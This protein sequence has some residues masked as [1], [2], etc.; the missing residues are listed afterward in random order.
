M[1]NS[2]TKFFTLVYQNFYFNESINYFNSKKRNRQLDA[3]LISWDDKLKN[4]FT[5]IPPPPA[6]Q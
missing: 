6:N 1:T 5:L 2:E 3:R 4:Q